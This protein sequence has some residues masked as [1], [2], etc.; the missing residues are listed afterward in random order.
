VRARRKFGAHLALATRARVLV[1]DHPL[2]PE[3]A[4]P[5]DV[6][7]V[8]AGYR[9]LLA[10][11]YPHTGIALVGESSAG[12]TVLSALLALSGAPRPAAAYLM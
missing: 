8:V 1:L 12:G 6:E 3:H 5:A 4:Y 2:A 7:A 10:L 11:G 9:W